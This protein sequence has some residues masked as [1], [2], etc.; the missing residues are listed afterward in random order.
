MALLSCC[1]INQER[2][3]GFIAEMAKIGATSKGGCNRQALTSLDHQGR[4][5][6]IQWCEKIHGKVR[7]DTMGNLFVHFDGE[8]NQLPPVLMSSHLDTQ[9]TGGK[10]D[11][12]YGVLAALEVMYCF[13]EA[14]VKT[15]HPIEIAVW[16][17]EE[18]ARFAPAMMG[19][20]VFAGIFDQ[21]AMYT[22]EDREGI[23]V[24]HALLES[25]QIGATPCHAFPI[26]AAL[27]LHI[28]QGP[29]LEAENKEI[30]IVT[31]VQGI[32]WYTVT[33]QGET[34]HAGPTPMS[35]RK[36]PVK[37]MSALIS[38]L[39]EMIESWDDQAKLSIGDLQVLPGSRNTVPHIA[40]F[41]V[42]IRHP[43]QETLDKIAQS[44]QLLIEQMSSEIVISVEAI[45]Q[46][47]AVQFNSHC[48]ETI[49]AVCEKNN[50]SSKK[51][52]SG[53]GHDSVYLSNIAPVGMIFTPCKNGISHN[54][55]EF[56]APEHLVTGAQ[57]LMHA[58]YQLAQHGRNEQ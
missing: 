24:Y 30:G 46:S 33:L 32:H 12:V 5:L 52:V 10:Y 26:K 50:L 47:A 56:V 19:S 35:M 28:E 3:L 43:D 4:N 2:L 48:I 21:Q 23:S 58:V 45:W 57:V 18:G 54:E 14:G 16:T 29:I 13:H 1:T 41:T 7:R 6:L 17:N 22:V 51:I 42:D 25:Q 49:N 36:D 53:A 9:P 39:Y 27:E 34:T 38:Q 40:T 37:A 31:G 11:G 8:N 44:F 20:G 55:A 15:E